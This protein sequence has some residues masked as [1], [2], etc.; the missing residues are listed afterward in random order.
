MQQQQR[1]QLAHCGLHCAQFLTHRDSYAARLGLV[2]R[3]VLPAGLTRLADS[4]YVQVQQTD[5]VALLDL[6]PIGPDYLPGHAHADTLS[7]ELSLFGRRV[8]VNSGTSC[9][10][11]GPERQRQRGTAAHNTVVIDGADSSEVWGGFRVARRAQPFDVQIAEQGGEIS[12]SGAHDGYRRLRGKPVHRRSWRFGPSS[13]TVVDRIEGDFREAVAHYFLHPDAY[14]L[15]AEQRIAVPGSEGRS[16][17]W[18]VRGGELQVVSAEYH[19]EFGVSL[20]SRCL[21]VH[22]AGNECQLTLHWN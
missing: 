16:A 18:R 1:A 19:P 4:G 13:L 8:F 14:V 2:P 21:R 12:V 7:F 3:E 22:L 9:Y 11:V 10:G 20:P 17:R 5:C 15:E 6:A